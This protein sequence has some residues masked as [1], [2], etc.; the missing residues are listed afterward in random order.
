MTIRRCLWGGTIVSAA[1]PQQRGNRKI[2]QMKR[3]QAQSIERIIRHAGFQD[4]LVEETQ[5]ALEAMSEETYAEGVRKE[6]SSEKFIRKTAGFA[7]RQ[8]LFYVAFGGGVISTAPV[9]YEKLRDVD[10]SIIDP[11]TIDWYCISIDW[12]SI[13]WISFEWD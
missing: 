13:D 3:F 7:A 6:G 11:S 12:S 10:W 4:K 2:L 8:L 9:L 5:K 1:L